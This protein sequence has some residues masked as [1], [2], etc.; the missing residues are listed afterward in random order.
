M[1]NNRK[2][3]ISVAAKPAIP[4]ERNPK[5]AGRPPAARDPESAHKSELLAWIKL[6][7][8][9]RGVL[10]KQVTFFEKQLAA[11]DSGGSTLSVESMLDVMK[12][13]GDML[14]VGNRIV[15]SGLKAL[16]KGKPVE[17]E[18]PEAIMDDLQGGRG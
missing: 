5:G 13:L 3:D 18:N 10:E 4:S 11:A 12:G 1:D 17:D 15:E 7:T 16:E 8:R 14:T 6:N 2:S 9:A